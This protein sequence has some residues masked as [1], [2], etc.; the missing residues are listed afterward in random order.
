MQAPP[1]A[2]ASVAHPAHV[3]AGFMSLLPLA[4]MADQMMDW[5]ALNAWFEEK[6]ADLE[7]CDVWD[8]PKNGDM[9]PEVLAAGASVLVQGG[10]GLEHGTGESLVLGPGPISMLFRRRAHTVGIQGPAKASDVLLAL[11]KQVTKEVHRNLLLSD[12][13][14]TVSNNI[15][16]VKDPAGEVLVLGASD[17]WLLHNF[18]KLVFP[19]HSGFSDLGKVHDNGKIKE[20]LVLAVT[21]GPDPLADLT[22]NEL[23]RLVE[24]I[25]SLAGIG[26]STALMEILPAGHHEP[27]GTSGWALE[28]P[29][30]PPAAPLLPCV[31]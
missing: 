16:F 27:L 9:G 6:G 2:H 18:G 15:R 22:L 20:D 12:L 19:P 3:H 28:P 23:E 14:Y 4:S 8:S 17:E 7:E 10:H 1:C 26:G 29:G 5:R 25:G 13:A 31:L 30:R 21:Y 11:S 24:K